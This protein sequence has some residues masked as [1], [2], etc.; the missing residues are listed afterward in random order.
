MVACGLA[1]LLCGVPLVLIQAGDCL[2]G[3]RKRCSLWKRPEGLV[4]Y[5]AETW[6]EYPPG[7]ATGAHEL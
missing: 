7:W 1:A 6:E 5:H 2:A 4:Q 3:K